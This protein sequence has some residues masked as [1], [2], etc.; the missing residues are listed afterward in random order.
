MF[1]D[2]IEG[3]GE[4]WEECDGRK[5]RVEDGGKGEWKW[6]GVNGMEGRDE[7]KGRNGMGEMGEPWKKRE[8]REE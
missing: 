7:R 4:G 6:D 5:G 8:S 3:V 2:R 1:R